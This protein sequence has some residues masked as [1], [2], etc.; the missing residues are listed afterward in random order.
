[1]LIEE[2]VR[3]ERLRRARHLKG[4]TQSELAERLGSDFE[5]VSRW[6]RGFT[7]PNA[8]YREKLCGILG[9]TAEE[10]G[11][12]LDL[13]EPLLPHTSSYVFLSSA[14]ADAENQFL[15]QLKVTLQARGITV[16]SN[17]ALRRQGA[18]NKTK[19]LQEAIRVAQAVLLIA[20][21]QARSSRSVQEVLQLARIYKNRV[22]AVWI[23]GEH[24]QECFPK[25]SGEFFAIIDVRKNNDNQGVDEIIAALRVERPTISESEVVA[26]TINETEELPV[27]PRNPYKGLKAFRGEDR[28]DFFG[29]YS[30]IEELATG[31]QAALSGEAPSAPN[32]RLLSLVGPSGSGKSSVVFAGLLPVLQA[33]ALSDSEEWV[34]LDPMVP[35][36]HPIES[37]TL[38]LARQMPDRSLRTIRDDLEDETARGLHLLANHLRTRPG[39]Y[40]VLFVDQFE[41][42]FTQTIS[43]EERR[44]F[45]DLLVTAVSEPQGPIIVILTLRADFYDRPMHY[46]EL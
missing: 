10:L 12:V 40:V 46:P 3:N 44:H 22:C 8:Y 33:G 9:K 38:A 11:L 30:L 15:T 20:S 36:V 16:L 6:E 39:I 1:M 18:E 4:W 21:P 43:E 34:Y 26:T 17:R 5:T 13:Q 35:G 27:E 23:D 2:N 29:R 32:A 41:E 14:Y 42:V 25:D 7:V 19:A 37:L 24:W 45:L 28:H 31:L